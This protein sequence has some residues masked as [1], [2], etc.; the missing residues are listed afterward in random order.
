MGTRFKNFQAT[1]VAPLGR[2][3]AGDLLQMQDSYADQSNFSQ[4]I[5]T[6]SIQ[7]GDT[8]LIVLKYGSGEIRI[9]GAL[10]V[11]G[12]LRGLGGLYAGQFSTTQRNAIASGLAPSGLVI[13]NST[14][15]TLQWNKGTDSVR[16]WQELSGDPNVSGDL[17]GTLPS[18]TVIKASG[19]FAL[20]GDITPP[21]LTADTND[22]AP[23]GLSG[24]STIR[25]SANAKWRLTG[26][27]GGAD[28]R[29]LIV[30]NIGN[31]PITLGHEIGSSSA[32]R[33]SLPGNADAVLGLGEMNVM[34]YDA[35]MQRWR[36]AARSAPAT[37]IGAAVY[38]TASQTIV[39]GGLAVTMAWQGEDMD[40]SGFH[41]TNSTRLQIPTG[42]DGLYAVDLQFA[43]TAPNG[44]RM[45]LLL[46]GTWVLT[47]QGI[48]QGGAPGLTGVDMFDYMRV[49][50]INLIA[51]DYIECLV[52]ARFGDP[53]VHT[54]IRSGQH[55]ASSS[56]FSLHK[57]G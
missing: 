45:W 6:G 57:I 28:G 38:Q 8:S 2:L 24:A 40:T 33:F 29:V 44:S 56:I 27:T 12:I 46:N 39:A 30:N 26:I 32:N 41:S 20:P 31:F 36:I 16:D 54:A 3:Y 51:G 17:A 55:L 9:T 18:P 14:S 43:A 5:G 42:L 23:T 50:F 47:A 4:I 21:S 7:V 13:F 19:S 35:I 48:D 22:Y 34:L 10:R 1:G 25:I 37:F 53:D 15:G 52:S 11:D 49:P